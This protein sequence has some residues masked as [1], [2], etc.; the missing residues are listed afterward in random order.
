VLASMGQGGHQLPVVV[1]AMQG[2]DAPLAGDM[3]LAL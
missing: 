1:A 2:A 3:L